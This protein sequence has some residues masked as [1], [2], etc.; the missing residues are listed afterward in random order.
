MAS[1]IVFLAVTCAPSCFL[2]SASD[3]EEVLPSVRYRDYNSRENQPKAHRNTPEFVKDLYSLQS[4]PVPGV[5]YEFL[6][7]PVKFPGDYRNGGSDNQ[8]DKDEASDS[9]EKRSYKE[10]APE[11][12]DVV[13]ETDEGAG[14]QNEETQDSA[15]QDLPRKAVFDSS[16]ERYDSSLPRSDS[17]SNQRGYESYP[18]RLPPPSEL[19][20]R[21]ESQ[22]RASST[23]PGRKDVEAP[24]S[25]F[26]GVSQTRLEPQPTFSANGGRGNDDRSLKP[27]VEFHFDIPNDKFHTDLAQGRFS[28]FKEVPSSLDTLV[29]SDV[30][31]LNKMIADPPIPENLTRDGTDRSY[32]RGGDRANT[33]VHIFPSIQQQPNRPALEAYQGYRSSGSPA[34]E[35]YESSP[36]SYE[37]GGNNGRSDSGSRGYSSERD[38]PYR[39]AASTVHIKASKIANETPRAKRAS[40][41]SGHRQTRISPDFIEKKPKPSQARATSHEAVRAASCIEKIAAQPFCLNDSSYPTG[42]DVLGEWKTIVNVK[43]FSQE[44]LLDTCSTE[45]SPCSARPPKSC[46]QSY[47]V[48]RLALYDEHARK[49]YSGEFRVPAGCTCGGDARV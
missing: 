33:M 45:K 41:T 12:S 36:G 2:A 48:Q 26:L 16:D 29:S 25:G 13:S 32:N 44:V 23:Y 40:K 15:K 17:G 8:E 5:D 47:Q 35:R 43:G 46:V 4:I 42:K 7:V 21:L 22:F 34:P 39:A 38:Y 14:V 30:S 1:V 10:P 49:L 18:P 19:R 24:R 31:F 3:S 20:P 27:T 28:T 37:D 11:K 9:A 6:P